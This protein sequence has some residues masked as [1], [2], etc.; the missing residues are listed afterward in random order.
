MLT[1]LMS[2]MEEQGQTLQVTK[3]I[4]A[5]H[6]PSKKGLAVAGCQIAQLL[7]N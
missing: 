5:K 1:F 6:Q 2:Q 7:S 3:Y 4:E